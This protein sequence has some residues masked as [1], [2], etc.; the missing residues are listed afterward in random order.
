MGKMEREDAERR[1]EGEEKGERRRE[2]GQS[3][4]RRAR[5]E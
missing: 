1:V 2:G 3:G 5:W 4:K